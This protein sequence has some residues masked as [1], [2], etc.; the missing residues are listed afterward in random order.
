MVS[1]AVEMTRQDG[2]AVALMTASDTHSLSGWTDM[3]GRQRRDNNEPGYLR[4]GQLESLRPVAAYLISVCVDVA[5]KCQATLYC[6]IGG[7]EWEAGINCLSRQL[8]HNEAGGH[9]PSVFISGLLRI[10]PLVP[11]KKSSEKSPHA[12]VQHTPQD[13]VLTSSTRQ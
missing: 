13:N 3:A 2:I 9:L 5:R 10:T 4:E 7:R 6:I 12:A 11:T 1:E 8:S